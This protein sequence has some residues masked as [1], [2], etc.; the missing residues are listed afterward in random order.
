VGPALR[1]ALRTIRFGAVTLVVQEGKILQIERDEKSRLNTGQQFNG[2][3][4]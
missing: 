4:F 3:G 1:E 2:S